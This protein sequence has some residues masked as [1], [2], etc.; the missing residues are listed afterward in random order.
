MKECSLCKRDFKPKRKEQKFCGNKCSAQSRSNLI[1]VICPCGN[2]FS[3]HGYRPLKGRGKYC[4]KDCLAKFR[5]VKPNSGQFKKGSKPWIKGKIGLFSGERA[6]N[7]QGGITSE[8]AKIRN[9]H[10]Y[11]AWRKT[12]FER[13]NYTC[14]MCGVIGGKL[15]A[16]HIKPFSKYPELRLNPDNGRTLC[17]NC[18]KNTDTYLWRCK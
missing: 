10:E 16:D 11:K 12:V 5:E 8:N 17:V 15:N 1:N 13:D 7:W 3:T 4:S 9:S 6:P 14:Q 18:H 2:K